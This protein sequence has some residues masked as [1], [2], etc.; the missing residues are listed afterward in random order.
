MS[1]LKRV[2]LAILISTIIV[3]VLVVGIELI[4][5]GGYYTIPETKLSMTSYVGI[6]LVLMSGWGTGFWHNK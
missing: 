4:K 2:S 6:A 5:I 3:S 1:L